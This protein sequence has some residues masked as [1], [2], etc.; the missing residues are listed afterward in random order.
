MQESGLKNSFLLVEYRICDAMSII[1]YLPIPRRNQRVLVFLF[2]CI[3]FLEF[4]V[5]SLIEISNSYVCCSLFYLVK[6]IS[7]ITFI[8]ICIL[9]NIYYTFSLLNIILIVCFFFV[10]TKKAGKQLHIAIL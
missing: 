6:S 9:L 7:R 3:R 2:D 1:F 5:L 8:I 4:L 10:L